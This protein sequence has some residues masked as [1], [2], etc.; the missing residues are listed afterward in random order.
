MRLSIIENDKGYNATAYLS[1]VLLNGIELNN[2][3]TAD[4]DEGYCLVYKTDDNGKT[5][6]NVANNKLLTEVLHGHVEI[7]N[8]QS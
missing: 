4:E 2:C 8:N 6:P 3:I 1:K 7:V 5:I